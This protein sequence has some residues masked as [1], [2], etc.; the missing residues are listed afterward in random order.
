MRTRHV[1][2]IPAEQTVALEPDAAGYLGRECPQPDCERYFKITPG[3]GLDGIDTCVC[4]YCGFK[5]HYSHFHTQDQIDHASSVIE[6]QVVGA[7]LKDLR[8]LEFDHRPRGSFGMGLSMRVEGSVPPVRHYSELDLETEVVC[9]ECTLRYAIF[10]LFAFCPDCGAH[11][12]LQTLDAN[13]AVV[14]KLL[15]LAVAEVDQELARTLL[16]SGLGNVVAAVDGW[17]RAVTWLHR[18]KA[19]ITIQV[20][21]VRFQNLVGAATNVANAFGFDVKSS[22]SAIEFTDAARLF[23]KRHV[24]AHKLGVVDSEYVDRTGDTSVPVGSK[25][26]I[27]SDEIRAGVDVLR[28]LAAALANHLETLP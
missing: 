21:G 28:R 16:S 12:N 6:Q 18:S 8:G 13:L 4:P 10:G 14:D 22:V 27:S 1:D 23:Q 2:Q 19:A 24:L 26:Q 20:G 15:N 9:E 11:N 25:L 17:G 5:E 3:T 7:L